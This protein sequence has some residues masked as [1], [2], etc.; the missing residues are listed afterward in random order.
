MFGGAFIWVNAL[1]NWTRYNPDTRTVLIPITLVYLLFVLSVFIG[2]PLSTV[3]LSTS[4]YGRLLLRPEERTASAVLVGVLLTASVP[5]VAG[6]IMANDLVFF[7]GVAVLALNGGTG[8]AYWLFG[9]V[10]LSGA[11]VGVTTSGSVLDATRA[12]R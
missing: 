5:L 1:R 12:T 6:L 10:A 9:V 8:A 4:R 11:L 2:E 3:L 7:G